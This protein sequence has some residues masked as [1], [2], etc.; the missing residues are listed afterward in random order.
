MGTYSPLPLLK[1]LSLRGLAASPA[2]STTETTS[3]G[4]SDKTTKN[5]P[6]G[7][8]NFPG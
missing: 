6:S 3:W 4:E 2:V 5:S 1:P 8:G 7:D